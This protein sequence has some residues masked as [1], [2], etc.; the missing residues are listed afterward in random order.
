[1]LVAMRSTDRRRAIQLLQSMLFMDAS[2]QFDGNA[3]DPTDSSVQLSAGDVLPDL[4]EASVDRHRER[5][6]IECAGASLTYAELDAAANRWANWLRQ[7]GVRRGMR[8]A[9]WL[10]RSIEVHA[11]LLGVL[12]SGASYVPLDTEYPPDR[13]QF[14]FENS[15]AA[16][17]ITNEQLAAGLH[18]LPT[19][20]S[21]HV[22][23]P[24]RTDVAAQP[25]TRPTRTETG[26][27][28]DAEAYVI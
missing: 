10:P 9:F 20:V 24:V 21:L 23:E 8:V 13:V 22:V 5:I 7:R 17:L 19:G 2:Q 25:Q 16:A 1:M 12:K 28:A 26:L 18:D 3:S 4:F 6:A 14:I 11:V 15:G 27:T